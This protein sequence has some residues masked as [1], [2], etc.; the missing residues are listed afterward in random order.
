MQIPSEPAARA[1]IVSVL[2]EVAAI[3]GT[4]AVERAVTFWLLRAGKKKAKDVEQP[5]LPKP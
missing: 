2:D 5:A 1:Y 3:H 4:P